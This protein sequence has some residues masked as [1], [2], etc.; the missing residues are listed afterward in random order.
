MAEFTNFYYF[1]KQCETKQT[2]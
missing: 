1:C 2:D